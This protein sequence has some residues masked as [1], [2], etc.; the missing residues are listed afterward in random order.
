MNGQIKEIIILQGWI[1]GNLCVTSFGD[2][3]QVMCD[4]AKTQNKIVRYD[5]SI[6]KQIIQFDENG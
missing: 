4:D 5:G 6:K 2:L 3:L 1:P